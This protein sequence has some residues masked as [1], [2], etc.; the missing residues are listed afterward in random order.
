MLSLYILPLGS[1]PTNVSGSTVDGQ[2]QVT[3]TRVKGG[4]KA[5]IPSSIDPVGRLED[6]GKET[7]KKLLNFQSTVDSIFKKLQEKQ[8]KAQGAA[9]S[10][11]REKHGHFARSLDHI[12]PVSTGVSSALQH[13]TNCS[14]SIKIFEVS[15]DHCRSATRLLVQL[16]NIRAGTLQSPLQLWP[17]HLHLSQ[18]V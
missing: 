17:G 15:A 6:I 9:G 7:V 2:V 10:T 12:K 4:R 11:V 18:H 13:L 5:V 1:F 3:T 8:E 16:F 14:V